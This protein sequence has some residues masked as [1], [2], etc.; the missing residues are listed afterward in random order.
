[1]AMDKVTVIVPAYN[2][3][4]YLG[5]CLKSIVNQTYLNLEVI[6]ID[7]GSTDNTAQIGLQFDH[8][9]SRIKV[10]SQKHQ[11]VA[12][13]RN[14]GLQNATGEFITFVDGDDF[15]ES[16]YIANLVT[17]LREYHSEIASS[18]YKIR[19][20]ATNQFFILTSLS[21]EDTRFNGVYSTAEWLQKIG[22]SLNAVNDCVW[23]KL[24]RRRLFEQLRFPENYSYYEDTMVLWQACLGAD[25]IS[26]ANQIDYNLTINR[27]ELVQTRVQEMV[28][29]YEKVHCL[30]EQIST[31]D[32]IDIN[33]HYLDKNLRA[34]LIDLRDKSQQVSDYDYYQRATGVLT[35]LD[36]LAKEQESNGN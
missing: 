25:R 29:A 26:F 36:A 18:F 5:D 3:Q 14:N 34:A 8:Q 17:Q 4:D 16:A 31:M 20:V 27:P 23:G 13:A 28:K 33:Y 30:Q 19:D 21:P 15:I 1:M 2:L 6:V 12:S 22:P 35:V 9:D 24:Y 7:D 32:L 10:I 11:G